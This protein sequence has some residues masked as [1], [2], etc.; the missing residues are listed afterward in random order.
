MPE[1]SIEEL[2]ERLERANKKIASLENKLASYEGNG[3]MKLYYSLNRKQWEMADL[4]NRENLTEM[5]I[6]DPK[7]KTFDRLK[8]ILK[9][10]SEM[11]AAVTSLGISLGVTGDEKKDTARKTSFLDKVAD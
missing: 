5:D 1:E 10:G 8:V 9:E 3:P 2:S 4:L 11:G 7:S 6:D